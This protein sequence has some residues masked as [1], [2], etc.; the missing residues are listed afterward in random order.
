MNLLVI[1]NG[2]AGSGKDTF[3]QLCREWLSTLYACTSANVHSSKTAK[4]ALRLLGW[5][6]EKTPET[7]KL[8]VD[9]TDFGHAHSI[10]EYLIDQENHSRVVFFHER[11]P[12]QIAKLK[13]AYRHSISLFVQWPEKAALEPDI[14]CMADYEYDYHTITDGD[15]EEFNKKARMFV[16]D[17]IKPLVYGKE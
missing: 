11:D 1:V 16:M 3:V 12:I 7:R 13:E 14:W 5:Q 10:S 17:V 9:L 2:P 15:L 8:L 4:Q 6:G